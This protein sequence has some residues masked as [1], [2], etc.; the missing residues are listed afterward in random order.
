MDLLTLISDNSFI[1]KGHHSKR[2]HRRLL[3]CNSPKLHQHPWIGHCFNLSAQTVTNVFKDDSI[4]FPST[5]YSYV[6]GMVCKTFQTATHFS[7]KILTRHVAASKKTQVI[8]V[9]SINSKQSACT[10]KIAFVWNACRRD[11]IRVLETITTQKCR[12]AFRQE[13]WIWRRNRSQNFRA[14]LLTMKFASFK[15]QEPDLES[16]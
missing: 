15:E 16:T 4:S 8:N 10:G 1:W 7:C 13:F 14:L 3:G 2:R 5:A 11:V 6:I 9:Q 12:S